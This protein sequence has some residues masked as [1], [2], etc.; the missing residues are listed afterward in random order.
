MS[1]PQVIP[2]GSDWLDAEVWMQLQ[3]NESS[4]IHQAINSW[5]PEAVR[6]KI[7]PRQW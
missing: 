6:G 5:G 1:R 2:W 4:I 3:S 7:L